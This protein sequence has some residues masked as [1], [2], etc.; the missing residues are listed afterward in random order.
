MAFIRAFAAS[1]I[2]A[3]AALHRDVFKTAAQRPA[4][5]AY[6][7]YFMRVFLES[8][9]ADPALPSLVCEDE[10]GRIVGFLGVVPRRMTMNGRRL[11]AAVSSQF[12][13]A[14]TNRAGL[15]AL[16]L[17]SAFFSGPQDLSISDEANETSR[18]IWEGLGGTTALWHS[19]YWTRPLRPARFAVSL[20]RTRPGL[21]RLARAAAPLAP[22][23]DALAAR[24]PY[25]APSA[26]SDSR[27]SE[28]LTGETMLASL[29]RCAQGGLR[30][31]YDEQ[32][33]AWV[34]ALARQRKRTGTLRA[35]V[36]RRGERVAG[37]Y[38]Y[39]LDIDRTAT[40]LQISAEAGRRGDVMDHLF[41]Q[42]FTDGAIAVSGRV[43]A[44]DVQTLADR[45]CLLHRRGP[46]VLVNA[47]HPELL[48]PFETGEAS[49]TPLDG[50]WC[51]GF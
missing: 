14:P 18:R 24:T 35:S 23:A 33:L 10:D 9:S 15:V 47:R 6:R 41:S 45:H 40:V 5:D 22:L 32:T 7:A 50:E 11:L 28:V 42:A 21:A 16:R 19:L 34:L 44:R 38:L 2:A 4:P 49:F 36:V 17:A 1:D 27:H 3:A 13:V 29:P 39:H 31:D 26:V 48:K 37:W 46:W 25:G 43:D 30:V 8:P 20:C 12:V 51:L